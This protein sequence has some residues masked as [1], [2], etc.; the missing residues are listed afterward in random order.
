MNLFKVITGIMT[1]GFVAV[2]HLI[3]FN[4]V[5]VLGIFWIPELMLLL[6]VIFSLIPWEHFPEWYVRV[7][8]HIYERKRKKKVV[9]F[10]KQ[11]E[12]PVWAVFDGVLIALITGLSLLLLYQL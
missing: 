1:L 11:R 9:Q 4:N 7:K 2:T 3:G 5:R 10:K 6:Y 12:I 8:N